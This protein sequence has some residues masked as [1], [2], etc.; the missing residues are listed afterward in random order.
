M[1]DSEA[2]FYDILN[3]RTDAPFFN[4]KY[5]SLINNIKTIGHRPLHK[6]ADFSS[7]NWNQKNYFGDYFPYIEISAIDTVDG[8]ITEITNVEKINA[9]S[10]AKKIVRNNDIIVSTT[11]PNRGAIGL[12]REIDDIVIAST[13]FAII[14]KISEDI[15]LEYLYIMLRQK[16][17]LLQMEQR[18]SG[19]N[20]PA[21]TENE[22]KKILIPLPPMET[23]QQIVDFY[24]CAVEEKQAKEQNAAA[25]LAGI[26]GYLLKELGIELPEDVWERYFEIGIL[27]IIGERLD[28]FYNQ[29]CFGNILSAITK[30]KYGIQ[31]LGQLILSYKKG[32]EVGSNEYTSEGI[33]FVRVADIDD[34]VIDTENADKKISKQK[35]EELKKDYQP[36]V[37]EI[38]Y[39]K[40]GTIGF[41]VIVEKESHCII[42][43]GIIRIICNSNVNNHFLKY[44][45]STKL[46]KQIAGRVGIGAVIKHLTIDK[47]LKLPVPVP[48]MEKQTEIAG[49]IQA[50]RAEANRLREEAGERL[51]FAKREIESMITV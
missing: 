22:L 13:G 44:L 24:Q 45:L 14:R 8:A 33:P 32:V 31:S 17:S 6:L 46:Y 42:S 19:G 4:D 21:I 9:P 34:F 37:G 43:G 15:L 12:V 25:L 49:H 51:E 47:W 39:S 20:Y 7:E 16:S 5:I 27:D 36:Q 2:R 35:F 11:R 38:L 1:I 23:Q 26:D 10:R 28:P 3:E 50:V 29:K 18:S 40:D 41:S 30:S 48:P